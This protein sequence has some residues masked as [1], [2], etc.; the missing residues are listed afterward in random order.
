MLLSIDSQLIKLFNALNFA[1]STSLFL[2][3]SLSV[4]RGKKFAIKLELKFNLPKNLKD[5]LNLIFSARPSQF[6]N[7]KYKWE[8]TGERANLQH[9]LHTNGSRIRFNILVLV[10]VLRLVVKLAVHTPSTPTY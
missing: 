8:G 7:T 1:S 10:L 2:C 6:V 5:K 9:K 4:S 3:H